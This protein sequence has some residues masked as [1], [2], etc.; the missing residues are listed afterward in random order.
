[1]TKRVILSWIGNSDMNAYRHSDVKDPG[2]LKRF[3]DAKKDDIEKL[4][5]FSDFDTE[6]NNFIDKWLK[7]SEL[8]FKIEHIDCTGLKEAG[9]G[10][11]DY[12]KIFEYV[13][14]KC[15]DLQSESEKENVLLG[16]HV[17]SGTGAMQS[18]LLLLGHTIYPG[19]MYET[20]REQGVKE[21][22][23]PVNVIA[24]PVITPSEY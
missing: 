7:P 8:S 24:E 11:T 14:D 1:M 23:L 19:V 22:N 15:L 4:I 13:V 10:V 21:I 3:V 18:I 20:S 17:T 6:T 9:A 5:I 2:P 16:F 12:N